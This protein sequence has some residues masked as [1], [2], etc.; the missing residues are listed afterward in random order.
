MNLTH[1]GTDAT[2]ALYGISASVFVG[3]EEEH[4]FVPYLRCS[5]W[6]SLHRTHTTTG[7]A[8]SLRHSTRASLLPLQRLHGTLSK[9]PATLQILYYDHCLPASLRSPHSLSLESHIS[10]FHFISFSFRWAGGGGGLS[11]C[12]HPALSRLQFPWPPHS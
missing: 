4:T 1:S 3:M 12:P 2:Y 10:R 7:P 9:P 8:C 6:T 11:L 5:R